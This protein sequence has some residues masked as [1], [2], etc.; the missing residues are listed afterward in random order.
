MARHLDQTTVDILDSLI[1]EARAKG[2]WLWMPPDVWRSP[3]ELEREDVTFRR[4]G[5]EWKL[6][7]PSERVVPNASDVSPRRSGL[8][9][10]LIAAVVR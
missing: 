1:A 7:A 3:D 5:S 10:A 9:T 4:W 6:R 8:S 2:M